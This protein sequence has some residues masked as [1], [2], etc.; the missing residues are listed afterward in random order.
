MPLYIVLAPPTPSDSME[1]DPVEYVFVK[2]GFCWP[3]LFVPT[4]WL[5]F[6]RLWP[7]LLL[8]LVGVALLAAATRFIGGPIPVLLFVFFRFYFA[9]EANGIRRWQLLRKGY[10]ILGVAEGRRVADAEVRF[11]YELTFPRFDFRQP[12]PGRLQA[13]MGEPRGPSA[14]SGE[15]VGFFPVPEGKP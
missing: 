9:L 1:A 15:V 14:E 2:D 10:R 13:A 3:C 12:P 5:I 7:V 6:R 8:Y 11:F 4:L